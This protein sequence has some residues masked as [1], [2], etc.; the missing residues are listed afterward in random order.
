MGGPTPTTVVFGGVRHEFPSAKEAYVWLIER[1]VKT[2]PKLFIDLNWQT[3]FVAKG[4]KRNYFGR[5]P[6]KMFHGSPHLAEDSNNYA[7]LLN[8]WYVNL[9]LS[10]A[11]KRYILFRFAHVANLKHGEDWQWKVSGEPEP[12]SLSEL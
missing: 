10:N 7:R 11:Q 3:A 12:P 5:S 6:A 9:N 1:F 8:G 2:Y 4:K